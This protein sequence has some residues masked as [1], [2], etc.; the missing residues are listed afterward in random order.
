MLLS[1]DSGEGGIEMAQPS[2]GKNS[3]T[4]AVRKPKLQSKHAAGLVGAPAQVT[5]GIS[6]ISAANSSGESAISVPS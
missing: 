6:S 5:L 3:T 4:K 2:K 1:N